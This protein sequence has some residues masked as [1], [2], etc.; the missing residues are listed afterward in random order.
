M[1]F[2]YL[3]DPLF[4][5]CFTVYWLNRFLEDFGLSAPLLR[6]YLND[7]ICIPFWVP[8]MVWV[9]RKLGLREYDGPP[10]AYE[11]VIPLLIWAAAFELIL[12]S[13]QG[14]SEL[15]FADPN[16]VLAYTLGAAGAKSFWRWW[17]GGAEKAL[18]QS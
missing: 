18:V 6:S 16:D 10:L 2:R 12:P 8:I 17:Y 14:W 15:A 9:N 7:L 4:L 11:T 1:P 3:K 5:V 13:M